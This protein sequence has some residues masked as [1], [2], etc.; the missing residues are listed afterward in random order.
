MA[1]AGAPIRDM[2]KDGMRV[3]GFSWS[4]NGSIGSV[5]KPFVLLEHLERQRFGRPHRTLDQI[6]ACDRSFRYGA[7]W[8]SCDATHWEEGRAPVPALA[9]SCNLFFYQIGLGLGDDGVHRALK[10]NPVAA[11][12]VHVK[13]RAGNRLVEHRGQ[14]RRCGVRH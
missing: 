4:S 3:P 2:G 5:V 11:F 12:F 7:R 10:R 6:R 8:L 9:K 13:R 14:F 1:V